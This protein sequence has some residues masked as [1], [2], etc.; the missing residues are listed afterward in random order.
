MV[1]G[2]SGFIGQGSRHAARL[3]PRVGSEFVLEETFVESVGEGVEA[4]AVEGREHGA[5][6][7]KVGGDSVLEGLE[8]LSVICTRGGGVVRGGGKDRPRKCSPD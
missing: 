6:F 8:E 2:G 5:V 1:G 3:W 7:E 4:R